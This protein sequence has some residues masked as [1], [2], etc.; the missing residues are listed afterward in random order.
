MQVC[1]HSGRFLLVMRLSLSLNFRKLQLKVMP[2]K[3]SR[4]IISVVMSTYLSKVPMIPIDDRV[5]TVSSSVSLLVICMSACVYSSV[6]PSRTLNWWNDGDM[7]RLRT[8]H[9]WPVSASSWS[10]HGVACILSPLQWL[11]PVPRRVLHLLHSRWKNLLQTRLHQ[12]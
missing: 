1:Y 12:V 4:C 5:S 2:L 3:K 9:R 10:R 7:C 11:P 8:T 6:G